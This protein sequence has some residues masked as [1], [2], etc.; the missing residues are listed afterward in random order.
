MFSGN[1]GFSPDYSVTTQKSIQFT[2][3]TVTTLNL[4]VTCSDLINLNSSKH[5]KRKT[6]CTKLSSVIILC[7]SSDNCH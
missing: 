1:I 3:A 2:I 4:T 5:I 6:L 7:M